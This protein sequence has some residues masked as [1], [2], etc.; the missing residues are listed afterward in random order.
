MTPNRP[1]PLVDADSEPFWAAAAEHSLR[2]PRCRSCDRHI[3]YP[4]ALCPHC[5]SDDLEWTEVSGLGTIYSFTVAR[6]P[7]GPAFADAVPYVVILV[8][9][10]E[11]AR[12]M[13][14]L[15]TDDVE[16]VR[17]GQRV[18]VEFEDAGEGVALPVFRLLEE[19]P[20]A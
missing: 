15:V 13:S 9:L 19:A 16:T 1:L 14:N 5:H 3:F 6:R 12:M 20:N 17:I 2:I 8:D 11:G 7:A 10:D 4:R 18:R